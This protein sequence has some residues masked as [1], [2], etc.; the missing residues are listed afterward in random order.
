MIRTDIDTY[1]TAHTEMS[2]QCA[3][4][5]SCLIIPLANRWTVA[6]CHD[7]KWYCMTN[8]WT[9]QIPK[10]QRTHQRILSLFGVHV[11]VE[12]QDHG[13]EVD[14]RNRLRLLAVE[15]SRCCQFTHTTWQ[16]L[17]IY[18][19]GWSILKHGLSRQDVFSVRYCIGSEW[20]ERRRKEQPEYV[21]SGERAIVELKIIWF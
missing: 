6:V 5:L 15:T 8:N 4:N 7:R 14:E 19:L 20:K 13:E 21:Y 16:R 9:C 18:V 10:R 3:I 12:Y 17:K 11:S 1:N 2:T